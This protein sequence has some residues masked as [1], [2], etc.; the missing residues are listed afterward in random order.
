MKL[1]SNL[2]GAYKLAVESSSLNVTGDPTASVGAGLVPA[3]FELKGN[4]QKIQS[5]NTIQ[6]TGGIA[7]HD[8]DERGYAASIDLLDTSDMQT[9]AMGQWKFLGRV[10][11]YYDPGRYYSHGAFLVGA[12]TTA[13]AVTETPSGSYSGYSQAGIEAYYIDTLDQA[14]ANASAYY[15]AASKRITVRLSN[16]NYWSGSMDP[17]AFWSINWDTPSR[18]EIYRIDKTE[19]THSCTGEVNPT[20][21]AFTCLFSGDLRGQ[22]KGKFFGESGQI[23]AGTYALKGG[24]LWSFSEALV[25]GFISKRNNEPI[26]TPNGQ[27]WAL[28][29]QSINAVDYVNNPGATTLLLSAPLD[30]SKPVYAA[31]LDASNDFDPDVRLIPDTN[32]SQGFNLQVRT[33]AKRVVRAREGMLEVRLCHDDPLL[34]KNPAKG[35]PWYIPYKIDTRAYPGPYPTVQ[36]NIIEAAAY[37]DTTNQS[38]L[39]LSFSVSQ[40]S[41]SIWQEEVQQYWYTVED[42]PLFD[43]GE[44]FPPRTWYNQ[45][46]S[47]FSSG[48]LGFKIKPGI[49][50][51]IY[52]G[53]IQLHICGYNAGK[54]TDCLPVEQPT[55]N[56]PYKVEIRSWSDLRPLSIAPEISNLFNQRG[57][58]EERDTFP[59]N[60]DTKKIQV[61]WKIPY[62]SSHYSVPGVGQGFY[63]FVSAID[64]SQTILRAYDEIDGHLLWTR[65]ITFS[66]GD[67]E[68]VVASNNR[69]YVKSNSN[70][71]ASIQ[72]LNAT[73]GQIITQKQCNFCKIEWSQVYGRGWVAK[74]TDSTTRSLYLWTHKEDNI[75]IYVSPSSSWNFNIEEQETIKSAFFGELGPPSA[76]PSAALSNQCTEIVNI[77]TSPKFYKSSPDSATCYVSPFAGSRWSVVG[78]IAPSASAGWQNQ[79]RPLEANNNVLYL[80]NALIHLTDATTGKEIWSMPIPP[81]HPTESYASKA[82]SN[83]LLFIGGDRIDAIDLST[84]QTVWS[85]PYPG[86]VLGISNSG[87]LYVSL[88]IAQIGQPEE[89]FLVAINLR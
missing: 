2:A 75:E 11:R 84:R 35:A 15:D 70:T 76:K 79:L 58:V 54:S 71:G 36:P 25:G 55:L 49:A 77:S 21:G 66:Y 63:F 56:I 1:S 8:S 64:S 67:P 50:V 47:T 74:V 18:S 44:S 20:T 22:M 16:L 69:I 32:R 9:V 53:D 89:R 62:P 38:Y 87:V 31:I 6:F 60:I 27:A 24:I 59:L 19:V 65:P 3:E 12:P 29:T 81:G 30:I 14:T 51:G 88:L 37:V 86:S 43:F 17:T 52:E 72:V 34:C 45:T 26:V 85:I 13:K 7:L 10:S 73:D 28:E 57:S 78:S 33:M 41:V 46:P 83:N 23:V 80:E 5:F 48:V 61:R 42:N 40:P 39:N 68:A 82:R 4:Q